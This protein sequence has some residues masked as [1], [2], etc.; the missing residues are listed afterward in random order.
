MNPRITPLICVLL[1]AA[2]GDDG[3][4]DGAENSDVSIAT[5]PLAGTVGGQ[6]WSLTTAA[7]DAFFSDGDQF[8][9]DGYGETIAEPCAGFVD[10]TLPSII[11]NVPKESGE[12]PLGL[13]LTATFVLNDAAGSNLVATQGVI[14]V[15]AVTESQI[16]GSARIEYDADNTVDGRFVA[17][18]CPE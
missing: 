18:I 11:L 1:V 3:G 17:S 12:H 5:T 16:M 8:W 2:C 15:D 4:L 9:V 10:A 7:S 6:P 13:M 14:I